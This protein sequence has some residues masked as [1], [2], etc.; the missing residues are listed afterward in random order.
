MHNQKYLHVAIEDIDSHID[1][2][3]MN[4]NSLILH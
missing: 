2:T 1:R 3:D 4:K